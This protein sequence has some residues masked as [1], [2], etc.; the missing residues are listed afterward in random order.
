MCANVSPIFLH[1]FMIVFLGLLAL[2][3]SCFYFICF[4]NLTLSSPRGSFRILFIKINPWPLTYSYS[5]S[6]HG[7][8]WWL[9]GVQRMIFVTVVKWTCQMKTLIIPLL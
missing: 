2:A 8:L 7:K 6:T 4:Q 1:T 9:W 5:E 3:Q